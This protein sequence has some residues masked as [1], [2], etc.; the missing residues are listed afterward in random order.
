[1]PMVLV[2]SCLL[3]VLLAGWVGTRVPTVQ[4]PA[5]RT[6]PDSRFAPLAVAL[7]TMLVIWYVWGSLH[8]VPVVHDEASYLLQAETFARGR[9]AMPSPPLPA[10]FEQFH[11][12][13][14][15]TF[16][17]KYPPGHG[18][19]LVPGIWLGLPGLVPLVLNG[20]AAALLF[21]LVRRVANGWIALLTFL[22]WLPMYGNLRFRPSYFSE[23][24]SSVLWLLGWWALI[25][26][27]ET[28]RG[29]WLSLLAVCVGWMAITRPLT[30]AA[31]AIPVG[32]VVL[33][34]TA[35]TRQWRALVLPAVLSVAIVSLI[36]IWNVKVTGNWR[37]TPYA[38]YSKVY[39]PYDVMGFKLDT[40]P[41]ERPLPPDMK[42][43]VKALGPTHAEHTV[44]HLPAILYDRWRA[45]FMDA[46]RGARLPFALFA[47]VSLAVLPAAGWFAVAASFL[48]TLFY[49][50]F[51]HDPSWNVY[52]LEI[53]PLFPF[54]A[55]CGVWGVWLA[56]QRRDIDIR[57][58]SLRAASPQAALAAFILGA[59]LLV[60]ARN[61]VVQARRQQAAR[62]AY[63]LNFTT[64][65]AQLPGE[66]TIVFIRYAP[67]HRIH[68]SLIA[69][70]ADLPDAR[71]WFVYD[72]G[73]EDAALMARAPDRVPYLFDESSG[74][75]QRLVVPPVA[76][77]DAKQRDIT[78]RPEKQGL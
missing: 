11:V 74:S 4:F 66:H 65:V 1:L 10:F 14:T 7:A 71:T 35:R 44:D 32:I 54:L 25:E 55:A 15:P 56:L 20:F 31:F 13:V 34:R 58:A 8:Q 41:P 5:L 47:I 68:T 63:K 18:M 45:I 60:V 16:A 30:A 9:W 28:G 52:Y 22:L 17:S 78:P 21:L 40:T 48:V 37:E 38:L 46:F 72:R 26:W 67:W 43:M 24:T 69:N 64:T 61:D 77:G 50:S 36:P 12:F 49:L 6:L 19:L 76:T 59:V 51:A 53:M 39:S 62:R 33:W 73:A 2:L 70:E 29:R 57:R 23:N 3:I 27:R 75:I 42:L